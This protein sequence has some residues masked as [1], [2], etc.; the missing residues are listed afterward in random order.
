MKRIGV[1]LVAFIIVGLPAPATAQQS[2][3]EQTLERVLSD[4]GLLMGNGPIYLASRLPSLASVGMHE[5]TMNLRGLGDFSI[6]L[7][8]ANVG[9]WSGFDQVGTGMEFVQFE[10]KLPPILPAPVVGASFRFGVLD[11]LDVGVRINFFPDFEQKPNG[12]IIGA[13]M[14]DA[15]L[16]VRYR[17]VEANG[18]VPEVWVALAGNYFSGRLLVGKDFDLPF[19]FSADDGTRVAGNLNLSGAPVLGWDLWQ[20]SPELRVA[21]KLG[22]F[23]PYFGVAA[24]LT[25][26]HID[27]GLDIRIKITLTEPEKAEESAKELV[28][29]A[30]QQPALF[31][32]R[33]VLGFQFAL[34]EHF[35]LV[36]EGQASL[37]FNPQPNQALD[38]EIKG[39]LDNSSKADEMLYNTTAAGS[40]APVSFT[41]SLGI[42]YDIF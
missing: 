19:D 21:W 31:S 26:G 32:L 2:S 34:S 7:N 17:A 33:P 23:H 40:L 37:T 5:P 11:D 10:D 27:A 41:A 38:P 15:G 4:F 20:V 36:L 24:D 22:W 42:R 12:L 1:A 30:T 39:I 16:S 6:G 25:F 14:L 35:H 28:T 29:L 8:L 13:G 3:I 18:G 9:L